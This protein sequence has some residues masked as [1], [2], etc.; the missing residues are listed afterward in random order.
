MAINSGDINPKFINLFQQ[1]FGLNNEEFELLLSNFYS[2]TISKK[3]FYLRAGQFCNAKAYLNKGCFRNFVVDEKG[4]ERILFFAFE[5]WW[6]GDFESY[7]SGK[8]GTNY[9]QALE[10]SELL[11]IPKE[12]FELMEKKI[13]KLNQWY[14]IKMLPAANAAKKKLEE[15]KILTPEE[16]YVTLIE[17]QP[18]IF[19]RV[20]LQYIAAYLNI[21]P[22]SLSRMR[23]R[24][25]KK[26]G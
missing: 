20:P 16:R 2:K 18:E 19:Q 15:I 14:V 26:N 25:P 5:D 6:V 9:V 11:I 13:P 7:Y 21:E 12:K 23:K 8:P 3:I 4:H 1:T 24:L 17:K 10:D 22:Q